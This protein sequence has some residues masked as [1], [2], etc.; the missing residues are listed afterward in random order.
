MTALVLIVSGLVY[1]ALWD[2]P[3]DTM[4]NMR[5]GAVACVV[6]FVLIGVINMPDGPFVRPHPVVWRVALCVMILY[7]LSLIFTLFQT[8]DD[9]RQFLALYDPE[10]G[11]P[12]PERTY[13]EDCR[14]YAPDHPKGPFYNL[15]EKFDI[16]VLC[17]FFGWYVK[18]LIIRDLW[19]LNILSVAFELAEYTLDCQLP[20][21]GECWWDHWIL[22]FILCNGLGIYLG[23]KTCEYLSMKKYIW[24]GVWNTPTIKGKIKRVV[25]QFTPYSWTSYQWGYTESFKKFLFMCF[26]IVCWIVQDLNTFYLKAIYWIP[27]NHSLN[28]YREV[29]YAFTGACAMKEMY[30]FLMSSDPYHRIGR[31][32]WLIFAVLSCEILLEIKHGWYILSIPI[33]TEWAVFWLVSTFLF[34]V[35][36]VWRFTV[37]LPIIGRYV[38][39][40][41]HKVKAM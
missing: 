27:P 35:W 41:E 14:I 7:I 9:T 28:L 26:I 36:V 4:Y 40:I 39:K 38:R 24:T 12:L 20:N 34:G 31:Y 29:I 32:P 1:V 8:V 23:V 37:P 16:F 11:K 19:V 13:C 2:T 17:H 22:D 21:F 25:S 15:L 5:R 3:L 10:L 6:I 30:S 18:A 33:H